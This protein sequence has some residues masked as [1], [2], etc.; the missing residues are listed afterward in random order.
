MNRRLA[1]RDVHPT[2][3]GCMSL[4]HAYGAPPSPEQ[5]A[6]LLN[7]ALDLGYDHLDPATL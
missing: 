2:G 6:R 4:S 3:L 7:A 5:G 1:W